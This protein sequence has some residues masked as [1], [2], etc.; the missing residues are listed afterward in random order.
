M[1]GPGRKPRGTKHNT[2]SHTEGQ[3]PQKVLGRLHPNRHSCQ[4]P[5]AGP[6][7]SMRSTTGKSRDV[8]GHP[9]EKPLGLEGGDQKQGIRK[10]QKS[11]P[12]SSLKAAGSHA[13]L[14]LLPSSDFLIFWHLHSISTSAAYPFA[15]VNISFQVSWT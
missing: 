7:V 11:R 8:L 14:Q 4:H 3:V 1:S 10:S 5:S 9:R 13:C 2:G 12:T 6:A 15:L